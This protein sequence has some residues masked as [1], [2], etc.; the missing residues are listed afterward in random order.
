MNKIFKEGIKSIILIQIFRT[1]HHY[2]EEYKLILNNLFKM[3][4]SIEIMIIL[5][6]L[7]K[8]FQKFQ[9]LKIHVTI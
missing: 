8:I 1:F 6:F 4:F 2:L 3:Y 7:L 9:K 5:R